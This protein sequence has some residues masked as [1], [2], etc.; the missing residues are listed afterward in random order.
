MKDISRRRFLILGTS[1]L[2]LVGC[3]PDEPPPI[4]YTVKD[5]LA[6]LP[7]YIA[8]RGSADNWPEHTRAAYARSVLAGAKAIEVSVHATSDGVLV[9]HHDPNTLRMTGVELSIADTSYSELEGLNVDARAWLGPNS[10]LLPIPK[11]KDVLD[12]HAP[13][14]VIFIEDKQG[15]NTE[16]LLELME[17]YPNPTE[18]FIWKQPAPSRRFK[19]LQAKGYTSW[20]YF[21]P[22]DFDKVAQFA[23]D[24]DYLGIYHSAPESLIKELVATGKPVICWEIH[25]RSLR[26]TMA[27]WGVQGMMCSNFPYVTRAVARYKSDQFATGLRPAGDLPSPL[28]LNRQPLI[29]PGPASVRT[30]EHKSS[31]CL[32]SM[33][34]IALSDYSLTF[35]MAWP[36]QVP[37]DYEHAGVAFG[38]ES[39]A[40]YVVREVSTVN[41]YHL[42]LRGSGS[43]ELFSRQATLVSGKLLD[44]VQTD[45]PAAGRW[46]HFRI[47]LSGSKIT[48]SRI[49]GAG[50]RFSV[51][52]GSFRGRYFS[53]NQNYENGPATLFRAISVT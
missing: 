23:A 1:A 18:H 2:A 47:Q 37:A 36:S 13:N 22:E 38:Q 43:M 10:V 53:L 4:T 50:W 35:D 34:P 12:E 14:R 31:Y 41:G 7:F 48:V 9:C 5:L 6:T 46:M 32:G 28:A 39:D 25:T 49:D 26:D 52:D 16:A 8:H 33:C 3:M 29:E 19:V 15:T 51:S 42:I 40:S 21:A 20:G 11:L 45:R 30:V 24:F 27:A 44:K 17:T